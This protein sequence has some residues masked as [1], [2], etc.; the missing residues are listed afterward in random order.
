MCVY[1]T[2]IKTVSNGGLCLVFLVE[3]FYN[4]M[5]KLPDSSKVNFIL[6]YL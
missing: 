1:G 5:N 3:H 4:K 6:P 2:K